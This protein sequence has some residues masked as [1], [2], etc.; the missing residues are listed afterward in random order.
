[1]E[2][3]P[4][5]NSGLKILEEVSDCLLKIKAFVQRGFEVTTEIIQSLRSTIDRL[6]VYAQKITQFSTLGL[7]VEKG[8]D[9]IKNPCRNLAQD[10]D[11]LIGVA[12][13]WMAG[14]ITRYEVN[15]KGG[16]V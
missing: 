6:S 12:I 8:N 10:I 1:M 11:E 3:S 2:N 7:I 9:F 5:P 15:F 16:N 4:T 14:T 13:D